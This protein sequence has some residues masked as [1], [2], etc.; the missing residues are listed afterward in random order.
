MKNRKAI[1]IFIILL[2]AAVSVRITSVP[3][4]DSVFNDLRTR[5]T[6]TR[7]LNANKSSYFYKWQNGDDLRLLNATEQQSQIV[8]GNTVTPAVLLLTDG[9]HRLPL[10]TI[11]TIWFYLSYALF[12]GIIALLFVK[13]SKNQSATNIFLLLCA[14]SFC[15]IAGW[16]M[17]CLKGQMYIL[18]AAM[19]VAS[20]Y[21]Y[22]RNQ[23]TAAAILGAL[24]TICRLPAVLLFLPLFLFKK[25]TR[26]LLIYC[27]T[28]VLAV[29]GTMLFF[30]THI[31]SDYFSAMQFYGLENAGAIPEIRNTDAI[32]VPAV[33]EGLP[34]FV[35]VKL[36]QYENTIQPD[37]FS[38]QKLLIQLSLPNTSGILYASFFL[39]VVFLF[40]LINRFNPR[41]YLNQKLMILFAAV[42]LVICE[43]F[44]PALRFN[45]NFVQFL[46]VISIIMFFNFRMNW[47]A[48]MLMTGGI[49]LNLIKVGFLPDAY[50]IGEILC[51]AAAVLTIIQNKALVQDEVF[52][53]NWFARRLT[54]FLGLY[55][56]MGLYRNPR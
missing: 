42:L 41:F 48:K 8:N 33:M 1:L 36:A 23:T 6:G 30:G 50:S 44:L 12:F 19:A 35:S 32:S 20:Y 15:L 16:R 4:K 46:V 10:A 14:A 47:M 54:G 55:P 38:V 5:V 21:C 52:E 2:L 53:Y 29:T 3:L 26:F 34:S 18:Y 43:Y 39:F 17:H 51:L 56:K 11:A 31:W 28:L 40:L 13:F 25:N 7:L 37:I 27:I 24:L 45:Y 9:L 49:F 22:Y